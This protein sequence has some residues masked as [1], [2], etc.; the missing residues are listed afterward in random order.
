MLIA[1]HQTEHGDP[2]GGRTKGAEGVCN[3]IGK[4]TISTNQTLP[5]P[6]ELPGTIHMEGPMA[7]AV[8]VGKGGLICRQWE[9]RPMVL[10]R[11]DALA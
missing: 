4:T 5:T 7:P 6:P 8:Y 10:W 1:N 11:L 3:P 2:K 9:E